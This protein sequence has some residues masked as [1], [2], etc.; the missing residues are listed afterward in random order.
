M[1]LCSGEKN[2]KNIDITYVGLLESENSGIFG[3][4]KRVSHK[5][6]ELM[7]EARI[8]LFRLP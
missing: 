6:A 7:M 1:G 2:E 3:G 8:K 4:K 5:R